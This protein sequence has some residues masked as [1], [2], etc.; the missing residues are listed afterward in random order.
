M[1]HFRWSLPLNP[2]NVH[3]CQTCPFP[4]APSKYHQFPQHLD[5]SELKLLRRVIRTLAFFTQLSHCGVHGP[6]RRHPDKYWS[7]RIFTFGKI[8]VLLLSLA[9]SPIYPESLFYE[10]CN[11]ATSALWNNE[12]WSP[13]GSVFPSK[14]PQLGAPIIE[15]LFP[16]R[17]LEQMLLV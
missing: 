11:L 17:S 15:L 8:E 7:M 9:F 4:P 5:Q 6:N 12:R 3:M 10:N 2:L 16:L 14:M 13:P 1:G